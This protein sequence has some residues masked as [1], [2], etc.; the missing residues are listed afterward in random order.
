MRMRSLSYVWALEIL[1]NSNFLLLWVWPEF[2]KGPLN[3]LNALISYHNIDWLGLPRAGHCCPPT[4]KL[5]LARSPTH[6]LPP[7]HHPFLPRPPHG[8]CTCSMSSLCLHMNLQYQARTPSCNLQ[9][10]SLHTWLTSS[11]PL[12]CPPTR[13]PRPAPATP[14]PCPCWCC[15]A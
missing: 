11:L 1:W 3:N 14:C 4:S 8:P 12:G 7:P 6:P 2:T 13:R 10:L 15:R 9:L 5:G